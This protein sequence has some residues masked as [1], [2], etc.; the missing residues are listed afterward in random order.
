VLH[1]P[2]VEDDH[3][4]RVELDGDRDLHLA[5]GLLQDLVQPLVETQA[6][7][8]HVEARQH[9]VLGVVL[10]RLLNES[11]RRLGH[12]HGTQIL[13]FK[14]GTSCRLELLSAVHGVRG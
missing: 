3:L 4:A 10:G 9:G 5:L 13:E 8:S 11:S 1:A 6:L 14:P 12:A 7:G 2:P